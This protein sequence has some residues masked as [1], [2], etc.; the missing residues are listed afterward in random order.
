MLEA[1]LAAAQA[2]L[3]AA[4]VIGAMGA[5]AKRD[6][7]QLYV[8]VRNISNNT[9]ALPPS[10]VKNE[11]AV[12]LHAENDIPDPATVAIVSYPWWQQLRK[13]K[14]FAMGMYIRD[15]SVLGTSHDA[16]PDDEERDLAPA[17]AV[18]TILNPYEWI[19]NK[20]EHELKLAIKEITSESTLRR[21]LWAIQQE[22]DRFFREL[23]ADD[24]DRIH[25]AEEMM[26][27]KLQYAERLCDNRLLDLTAPFRTTEE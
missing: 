8:G 1:Q 14:L 23:P 6:V 13:H 5:T 24:P 7:S 16:A 22:V 21:L 10:P 17:H 12:L 20:N 27:A 3:A 26:G 11:A 19:V 4:Q 9:I 18:N 15:D 2:Q 25:K